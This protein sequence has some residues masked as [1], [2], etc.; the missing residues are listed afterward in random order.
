MEER[1]TAVVGARISAFKKKMAEVRRIMK[2]TPTKAEAVVGA[3]TKEFNK[4]MATVK[5]QAEAL[6]GKDVVIDFKANMTS[7]MRMFKSV[8]QHVSEIDGAFQDA[9]GRWRDEAG[10]FL[11]VDKKGFVI[12]VHAD[13]APFERAMKKMKSNFK[14]AQKQLDKI[15]QTIH[16]LTNVGGNMFFGGLLAMSPGAIPLIAGAIASMAM[17]GPM[18]G[19]LAGS[20]FSLASAFLLAGA[21]AVA[22][23]ALAIP[24]IS[25]VFEEGAKL[26][27]Q[28]Q[29]AKT[30]FEGMRDTYRGIVKELEKPVLEAFTKSMDIVSNMLTMMKPTFEGAANAVNSLMDSLKASLGTPPVKAFFDYMNKTAGPMLELTGKA[31]GNFFKGLGSMMVAFAPLTDSVANGFLNMSK[32]FAEWA[33]GLSKSEK[34]QNFVT[35]VQEN[36]PKV[37]AIFRD[38]LAGI[39]YFFSAFGPLAADMMTGLA[40]LMGRFKEWAKTLDENPAFQNFI[41]YIQE[42]GPAMLTFI[43]EMARLITNLAIALAP[44][45]AKILAVTNWF[46]N[47]FNSLME[48]Y[49][50]VGKIIG[51]MIVL[52][53]LFQAFV[54]V[55]TV[56]V[57]MFGGFGSVLAKLFPVIGAIFSTLKLNVLVGLRMMGAQALIQGGRMAAGFLIAMGPVGWVIATVIGLVALIIWKWDEIVSFTKKYWTLAWDFIKLAWNWIVETVTTKTVEMVAKIRSKFEEMKSNIQNKIELAKNILKS[58]WDTIVTNTAGKV[59]EMVAKVKAKFDEMKSAVEEKMNSAKAKVEEILNAIKGVFDG[60]DLYESGK[61]IIQS[62]IDGI[63]AMKGKVEGAVSKIAGAIRDFFPFSPA[64]EGPLSTLHRLDFG[65]PVSDS[66]MRAKNEIQAAMGNMLQAPTLDY[67][68][69]PQMSASV[70]HSMTID[71]TKEE[72]NNQP[73]VAVL[74]IDGYEAKGVINYVTENQQRNEARNRRMP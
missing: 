25:K 16:T 29:K 45:G 37:R 8:K 38:A 48:K 13:L 58:V 68:M 23:G 34:F 65:G 59:V 18:I 22:F 3:D 27:A 62:A 39:T 10:Q 21:G 15:S 46:L 31:I 26:N 71:R 30:A 6:D 5:A 52:A 2:T 7:F 70:N 53:G 64:K 42:N 47:L 67:G 4:K 66:I 41:K 11:K 44:L 1:L 61:K 57:T 33:D 40:G 63:L 28:Q 43:G 9:Q 19:V 49:P 69:T 60:I 54:P 72:E 50:I 14:Q 55:I 56:V 36:M 51:V 32:R 73:Q 74:Q 17:L 35:Y 20:M 24:T 12:P